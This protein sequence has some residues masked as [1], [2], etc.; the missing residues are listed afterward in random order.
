MTKGLLIDFGGT[1]DTNGRHW[2]RVFQDAY[3][4]SRPDIPEETLRSAYVFAERYM[5]KNPVVGNGFNFSQTIRIKSELQAGFLRDNGID[6]S[7]T[8]SSKVQ[9]YCCCLVAENVQ[10][11]SRPVLERLS[12][13]LPLVLVTNFYGNMH[14]VLAGL[15]L[16]NLFSEVIES[17]VVGIRKPDP[18]IFS[19]GVSA[20]GLPASEVVAV[21]DSYDKDII[22][23]FNAGCRTVWLAGC[24]WQD[25]TGSTQITYEC[26]PDAVINDFRELEPAIDSL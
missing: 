10:K 1:V 15:G 11:V 5:G 19:L 16:E 8:E 18:L 9:E 22:P 12:T 25:G 3:R 14:S 17:A 7:E 26:R 4:E 13:R 21:G 24:G 23:A 6:F 20:L 2:F